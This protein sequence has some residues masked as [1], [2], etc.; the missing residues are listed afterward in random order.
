MAWFENTNRS[1]RLIETGISERMAE[2]L[3][4]YRSSGIVSA[5]EMHVTSES[6]ERYSFPSAASVYELLA[7]NW[8]QRYE[9]KVLQG[10]DTLLVIPGIVGNNVLWDA[11]SRVVLGR[12]GDIRAT[13]NEVLKVNTTQ[14][15]WGYW[16][17]YSSMQ[18]RTS[19]SLYTESLLAEWVGR[20]TF[21][22]NLPFPGFDVVLIRSKDL[23]LLRKGSRR[24]TLM[25]RP[26][27]KGGKS[28]REFRAILGKPPYEC[29][30]A[31][32]TDGHIS[33]YL[34]SIL[35]KGIAPDVWHIRR[36]TLSWSS[37]NQFQVSPDDIRVPCSD[38]SWSERN[39]GFSGTVEDVRYK[40]YAVR[41]AVRVCP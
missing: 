33:F 24:P 39:F 11:L 2:Q 13:W 38:W 26:D 32:S 3:E 4:I 8:N 27:L 21:Y 6:G 7:V 25:G 28:P 30:C 37:D 40:S 14:P 23:R 17:D 36:G 15:V 31:L 35:E 22:E 34:Q 9:L 18:Y 10:F 12:N 41:S 16:E 29:E 1:A 5:N 20:Q 19:Q